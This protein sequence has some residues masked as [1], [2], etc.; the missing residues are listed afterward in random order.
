MPLKVLLVNPWIYDFAAYNM[1]STP[2]GLYKT[3]EYLSQFDV[4]LR[5]IDCLESYNP[6]RYGDGRYLSERVER[7][8]SLAKISR[9][10]KRYGIS[11]EDFKSRLQGSLPID[12]VLVT[13]V[14]AYWYPGVQ[15][16]IKIIKE[17]IGKIPTI[18]GGLYP[19]LYPD[20]ALLFSGADAV[21][22]G[23][24]EG[25]SGVTLQSFGFRL[26]K[27]S[28]DPQPYYKM[29]LNTHAYAPIQT[30]TGC[31][32]RC[33]YCA[34]YLLDGPYRGRDIDAVLKEIES[35]IEQGI[36]D[37]AFYDDALLY[38]A[39]NHIKPILREV[40]KRPMSVRFHTPNGLHA[41]FIDEEVAYLMKQANFKTLRIGFETVNTTRQVETGGKT[42]TQEFI[43]AL[44]RL[45][46]AGFQGHEI[47]VYLMYGLPGQGLKEVK[48]GVEFLKSFKVLVKLAEFS[49]IRGTKAWEEL[50]RLGVITDDLDPILTNNS[51]FTE[52]FSPIS[53]QEL[54]R[55]KLDVKDYN[56]ALLSF[57]S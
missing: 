48:E 40:I 41:R 42:G 18:L 52:L 31:P 22:V 34:S 32:Y 19:K 26:R 35:L 5:Y 11:I 27:L 1:W 6:K 15:K 24:V 44:N 53:L 38:D 20:H 55:L 7:P 49:P 9:H 17:T 39:D 28:R 3:A 46:N 14:M 50:V 36:T 57:W 25:S 10:Y 2:L 16:V 33:S 23:N 12:L 51:V 8:P 30:S 47:G 37:I 21:C 29:G 54:R 4:H 13:S 43:D 45:K 56:K